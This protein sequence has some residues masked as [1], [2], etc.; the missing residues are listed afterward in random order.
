ML[1]FVGV[2]PTYE[3]IVAD[4]PCVAKWFVVSAL[5]AMT[6]GAVLKVF[7]TAGGCSDVFLA[8]WQQAAAVGV[9]GIALKFRG[10]WLV[11]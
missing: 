1:Q 9:K 5:L 6:R 7:T 10:G 8:S 4:A 11:L 2:E 3:W